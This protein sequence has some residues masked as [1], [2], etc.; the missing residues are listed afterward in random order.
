MLGGGPN[1]MSAPLGI[2]SDEKNTVGDG[3]AG[4]KFDIG[5]PA[6]LAQSKFFWRNRFL[7]FRFSPP[8][9]MEMAFL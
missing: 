9:S 7:P 6:V 5:L 2:F 4:R 1:D 8:G 3:K